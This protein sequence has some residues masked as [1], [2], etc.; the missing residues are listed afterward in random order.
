[1]PIATA[2]FARNLFLA[3]LGVSLV[4]GGVLALQ[5]RTEYYTCE[6][7][8]AIM[9]ELEPQRALFERLNDRASRWFVDHPERGCPAGSDVAT[10]PELARHNI[11]AVELVCNDRRIVAITTKRLVDWPSLATLD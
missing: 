10:L 5:D 9:E 6:D 1:M 2:P 8:L 4:T 11:A 3:L 7:K